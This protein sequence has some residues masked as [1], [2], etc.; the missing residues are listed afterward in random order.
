MVHPQMV[1]NVHNQLP[2]I[3]LQ[4]A[5]GKN[6]DHHSL[7]NTLQGGMVKADSTRC[8]QS[9]CRSSAPGTP[10][11]SRK[12]DWWPAAGHGSCS[13]S[14]CVQHIGHL[15]VQSLPHTD[16]PPGMEEDISLQLH[17]S[18]NRSEDRHWCTHQNDYLMDR[19]ELRERKKLDKTH[20][21]HVQIKGS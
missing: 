19:A 10:S 11:L 7:G 1:R 6:T 20:R 2:Y 4:C 21:G 16:T 5:A 17:P 3:G 9:H 18:W 8:C 13:H 12:S 15:A 14:H